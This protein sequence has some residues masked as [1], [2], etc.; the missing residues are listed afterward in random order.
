LGGADDIRNLWPEPRYDTV[1]NSFVKDQLEDYLHHAVCG[2]KIGLPV[3]QHEI[4]TNWIAA[5]KKYFHTDRPL[6]GH[7]TSKLSIMFAPST[8]YNEFAGS[9][10]RASHPRDDAQDSNSRQ[11]L[12]L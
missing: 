2:G 6:S 8:P 9:E 4:A 7:P 11:T 5:Y 10:A 3:A 12:P 1:W